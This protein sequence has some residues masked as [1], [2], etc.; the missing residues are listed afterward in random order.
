[1]E[2]ALWGIGSAIGFGFGDFTAR[3]TSRRIGAESSLLAVLI[4][5]FVG[6]TLLFFL[7]GAGAA[8]GRQ[9]SAWVSGP[10]IWWSLGSG[11]ANLFGLLCLYKAL[12]RGPISLAAPIVA[13]YPAAV[14]VYLVF[15]GYV[16]M[17]VHLGGIVA[18]LGGVILL[19]RLAEGDAPTA[20][21][22]GE[23][24]TETIRLA[25]FS[26][27]GL[28]LGLL[29]AQEVTELHG[30]LWGAWGRH[31]FGTMWLL[32]WMAAR[33][34]MPKFPRGIRLLLVLQALL[35]G[36]GSLFL[37]VAGTGGGRP[38]A[39][40]FSS[41]FA[42]VVVVLGWLF[43]RERISLAQWLSMGVILAGVSVLALSPEVLPPG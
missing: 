30:P 29:C 20:A 8:A 24:P 17:P 28:A 7:P 1:M 22:A 12:A 34:Q 10:G 38:L 19:S 39:A 9:F 15:L 42:A 3:F 13:A 37:F 2:G 25:V 21:S 43:L 14:L 23:R 4:I 27:C 6:L 26:M 18:T 32:A 41:N 31:G 11:G 35:E 33:G 36:A 40:V 16:L 5:G